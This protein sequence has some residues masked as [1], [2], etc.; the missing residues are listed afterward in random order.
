MKHF[1]DGHTE[2]IIEE[3]PD[4]QGPERLAA[5][6]RE[7]ELEEYGE[8]AVIGGMWRCKCGVIG[9]ALVEQDYHSGH[10]A[11]MLTAGGVSLPD[12][13]DAPRLERC[14]ACGVRH[15]GAPCAPLPG[16][17]FA[18]DGLRARLERVADA[19]LGFVI[20]ESAVGESA[21]Q[22]DAL[23]KAVHLLGIARAALGSAPRE[24]P[25]DR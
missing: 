6:L 14:A 9:D 8:G 18:P 23:V 12:S 21:P 24:T 5:L 7:H 2:E 22:Y 10:L 20:A 25:E 13:G 4:V 1:A 19:A 15:Q 17:I 3:R 11:K 16:S